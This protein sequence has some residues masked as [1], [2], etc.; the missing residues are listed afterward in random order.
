MEKEK[1]SDN[2]GISQEELKQFYD[3]KQR[4]WEE[5]DRNLRGGSNRKPHRKHATNYT[6]PKRRHRKKR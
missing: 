4:V 2:N 5:T 3:E 1:Y 6:P